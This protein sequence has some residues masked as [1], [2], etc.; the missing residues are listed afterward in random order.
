VQDARKAAGL[1]VSDRIVLGIGAMGEIAEAM[2]DEGNRSRV[3]EETLATV[4][5]DEPLPNATYSTEAD[6]DGDAVTVTLRRA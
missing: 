5:N 2:R 4:L 6:L 1:D 3:A